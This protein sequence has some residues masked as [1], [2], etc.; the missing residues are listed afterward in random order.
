MHRALSYSEDVCSLQMSIHL[1]K[2]H[3]F[4][5]FNRTDAELLGYWNVCKALLIIEII[6]VLMWLVKSAKLRIQPI[7]KIS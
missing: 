1:L 4:T 6:M 2:M 7:L 3:Y 5:Y